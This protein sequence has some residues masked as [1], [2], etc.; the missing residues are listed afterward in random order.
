MERREKKWI[1]LIL[2][3]L[4]G[5]LYSNSKLMYSGDWKDDTLEGNGTL[6]QENGEKYTGQW[7]ANMKHG[8]GI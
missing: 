1:R 7:K 2:D 8:K 5:N 4:I 3:L 6:N